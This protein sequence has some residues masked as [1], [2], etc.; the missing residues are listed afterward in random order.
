MIPAQAETWAAFESSAPIPFDES[1]AEMM[2]TLEYLKEMYVGKEHPF[3]TSSR[4]GFT[5]LIIPKT[6][7]RVFP[8]VNESQHSQA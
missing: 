1:D 4:D 2:L 5:W 6:I 3:L 8:D 7:V